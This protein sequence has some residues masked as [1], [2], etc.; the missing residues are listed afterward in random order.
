MRK[1]LISIVLLAPLVVGVSAQDSSSQDKAG[2][3]IIG[4]VHKVDRAAG[5]VV[6]KTA[7]GAKET[8]HL[9]DRCMV[10]T[11]K[12]V[13][14]GTEYTVK[15]TEAGGREIGRLLKRVGKAI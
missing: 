15:E 14:K 12:G 10:D 11:G 4:A 1:L 8:L 13:A 9:T 7:E 5:K 3:D 6:V 2:H